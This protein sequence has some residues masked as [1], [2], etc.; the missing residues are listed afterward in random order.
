VDLRTL[1]LLDALGPAPAALLFELL[2]GPATEA[3][4]LARLDDGSQAT[5]NRHLHDLRRAGIV[6]QEVGKPRAPGRLWSLVHP[7]ETEALLSATL[8]LADA[9][10][11]R[12]AQRRAAARK[13]LRKAR[14]AR[15]GL[16]PVDERSA[17]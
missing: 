5:A 10:D 8:D 14:A 16:T 6:A 7:P 2:S 3:E 11:A 1:N 17:P 12:N 13:Q 9:I 4:L 15:V